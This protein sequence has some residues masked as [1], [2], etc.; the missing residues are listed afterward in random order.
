MRTKLHAMLFG[1]ALASMSLLAACG[2][3]ADSG[4]DKAG[5][6]PGNTDEIAQH[7]FSGDKKLA[8]QGRELFIENNCYSCHGGLA[9]GAMGPSLRDTT[10][11]YGGT[12]SMIYHTI[13]DG[14]PMGMPAWGGTLDDTQIEALTTYIHSLRT[15]AEPQFFFAANGDSAAASAPPQAPPA[16]R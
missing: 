1:G 16:N 10:W 15:R 5:A 8:V 13:H 6:K 3:K 9:G 11:K 4:Q 2:R 12:D 7:T 14:R